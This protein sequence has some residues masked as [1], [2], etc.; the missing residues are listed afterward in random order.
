MF[1]LGTNANPFVNSPM[2]NVLLS[3]INYYSFS[4]FNTEDKTSP[5]VNKKNMERFDKEPLVQALCLRFGQLLTPLTSSPKF[6]SYNLKT[7]EI[8]CHSIS[9]SSPSLL[10][11]IKSRKFF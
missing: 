1:D 2:L 8:L 5:E 7:L 6:G 11:T 9:L 3:V 10:S 4:S